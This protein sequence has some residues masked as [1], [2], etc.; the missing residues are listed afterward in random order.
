MPEHNLHP[1][2]RELRE[3]QDFV[4]HEW[5]AASELARIADAL[6]RLIALAERLGIPPDVGSAQRY[7]P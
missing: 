3:A 6:D 4:D 5:A 1:R 2:I 7:I